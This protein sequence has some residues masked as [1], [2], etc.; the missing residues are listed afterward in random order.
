MARLSPPALPGPG[1]APGP[2]PR[3][4]PGGACPAG[5]PRPAGRGRRLPEE[6]PAAERDLADGLGGQHPPAE[7]DRP[8]T[9]VD[10]H[11]KAGAVGDEPV[12]AHILASAHGGEPAAAAE[13]LPDAG[14]Q[15]GL[16]HEGG[17][18]PRR[19]PPH[20]PPVRPVAARLAGL[21]GGVPLPQR[22]HAKHPALSSTSGWMPNRAGRHRTMSASRPG[23]RLPTSPSIPCTRAGS[24]VYFARY[25]STRSLSS[26]RACPGRPGGGGVIRS[27]P[28]AGGHPWPASLARHAFM[29][30]AS[31]HVLRT[32][33]PILP[34]P[35]ESLL[36]MLIAPSSWSGPSAAMV[37]GW[38]RSQAACRSPASPADPPCTAR[39]I[40][41]CSAAVPRPYGMVGVVEEHTTLGSRT[42]PIRSG[43]CPPPAPSTW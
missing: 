19:G 10:L 38:T 34:M 17:G 29:T 42:S 3:R 28:G 39:I 32:V 26:A 13:G 20:R 11:R 36:T 41:G 15:G 8:V 27:V 24:A 40:R 6:V 21:D 5:P 43:T 4:A 7:A 30:S 1:V 25:R 23:A 9:R 31:C 14:R 37:A 33:S 16:G 2:R 18:Q 12:P 22:A 35:W